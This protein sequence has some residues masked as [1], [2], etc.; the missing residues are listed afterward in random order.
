M[1]CTSKPTPFL[2]YSSLITIM[3]IV[4]GT[5]NFTGNRKELNVNGDVLKRKKRG[6]IF[7]KKLYI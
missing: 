3:H 4:N 7:L 5:T 6:T 2:K 1:F